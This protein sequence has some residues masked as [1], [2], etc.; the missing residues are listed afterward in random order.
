VADD[1]RTVV[2]Q[3]ARTGTVERAVYAVADDS[4]RFE[5]GARVG[6]SL[7]LALDRIQ[8]ERQLVAA[9]AW[10]PGSGERERLDCLRVPPDTPVP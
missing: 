4:R 8:R 1:L 7:G 3:T 5:A 2:R 9:S 10:T 6:V